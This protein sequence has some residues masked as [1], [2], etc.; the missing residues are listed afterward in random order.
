M[1]LPRL[2]IAFP[3]ALDGESPLSLDLQAAIESAIA[4]LPPEDTGSLLVVGTRDGAKAVVASK[5][6]E[7]WIVGGGVW[8]PF[9]GPTKFA[10]EGRVFVQA[11]W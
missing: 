5:F 8:V 7:H 9:T 4:D 2:G 11:R 3:S 1:T 10:P 6:G